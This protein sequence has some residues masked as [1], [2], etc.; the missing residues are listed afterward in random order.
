MTI[1]EVAKSGSIIVTVANIVVFSIGFLVA[2]LLGLVAARMVWVRAVR[3]TRARLERDR[4]ETLR[5]FEARIAGAQARSAVSIR[6][7]ERSLERER[8]ISAQARLMADQ[9]SSS[10]ALAQAERDD[11]RASLV[12]LSDSLDATRERL[13]QQEEALARRS[14]DLSNVRRELSDARQELAMRDEDVRRAEDEVA[15][16]QMEL[17]SQLTSG[18]DTADAVQ[19]LAQ[20]G[21]AAAIARQQI[22]TLRES[23][24]L[25]RAEKS[26]AEASAARA[27]LL[28]DARDENAAVTAAKLEFEAQRQEMKAR[29]AQLEEAARTPRLVSITPPDQIAVE[30]GTADERLDS[31]RTSIDA[32]TASLTA[33][34][35]LAGGPAGD[36]INALLDEA[37]RIGG[38]SALVMS[39]VEARE[40]LRAGRK[41]AATSGQS[42]ADPIPTGSAAQQLRVQARGML[43]GGKSQSEAVQAPEER[44]TT[45]DVAQVAPSPTQPTGPRAGL[46]R[47]SENDLK[48]I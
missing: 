46:P 30:D 45:A 42:S 47:A 24:R 28:L 14:Q 21:T 10:S 11:T 4:P 41:T 32:M 29:I 43:A 9:M 5:A 2:C 26:A 8:Q 15:S 23:V 19:L 1:R 22:E 12:N 18:D 20:G 7:L 31:L 39:L 37:A 33:N 38:D 34:A 6:E 27:R 44:Q 48:V 25:L 16:L 3:I 36:Q 17:A 40:R 35:A 13:R